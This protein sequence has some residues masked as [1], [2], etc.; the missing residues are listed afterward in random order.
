MSILDSDK[1]FKLLVKAKDLAN[2]TLKITDN[3]KRFPKKY[4][5]TFVNRM[6]N[7]SLDI[8]E[9]INT[10]NELNTNDK[11]GLEQRLRLQNQA[12]T[13][14]KTLLFLINLCYKNE[15]IALNERQAIAW[16]KYVVN[17]KNMTI[18]WHNQDKMKR[19]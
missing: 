12:I 15:K 16:A 2:Y 11:I 14:C 8:Y 10:A 6:Q 7:L 19:K 3:A 1:D 4:R 9:L 17:V 13:K 5:F 18:K